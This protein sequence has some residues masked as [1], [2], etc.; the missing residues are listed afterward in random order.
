VHVPYK[1]GA[2]TVTDLVS[3]QV[4]IL[5]AGPLTFPHVAAG[6]LRAVA[7]AGDKR[8]GVAPQL[9]TIAESGVPGFEV[10]S[11]LGVVTPAGVPRP[12]IDR[13]HREIGDMLRSSATKEK[14]AKSDI[15]I[16]PSTPEELAG[17]I[18]ADFVK[19]TPIMRQAGIQ[20]E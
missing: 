1:S 9:P 2:Q 17:R 11:W 18:R 4:D 14:F 12:I 6:R 7:Y 10:I 13:L 5:F 8:S 19:W 15:D 3:G 16:R 20:P